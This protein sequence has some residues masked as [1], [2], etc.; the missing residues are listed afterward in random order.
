M[1]APGKLEALLHTS[2]AL[3]FAVSGRGVGYYFLV[4]AELWSAGSGTT[5]SG[6]SA[7]SWRHEHGGAPAGRRGNAGA[8]GARLWSGAVGGV[9]QGHRRPG[10]P[11]ALPAAQSPRRPDMCRESGLCCRPASTE[12]GGV[13]VKRAWQRIQGILRGIRGS[14]EVDVGGWS[15]AKGGGGKTFLRVQR[16]HPGACCPPLSTLV[17]PCPCLS[18]L[19]HACPHLSTLVHACPLLLILVH[20]CPLLSM[21]V[22]SCPF[23]SMLVHLAHACPR[24]STHPITCRRQ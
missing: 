6:L 9:W 3:V 10:I 5:L 23:L 15:L 14:P 22:H 24:L 16:R 12:A 11:G 2:R 1:G 21:L 17:H 13:C 4:K 19:A 18:T 7:C 8:A 20:T